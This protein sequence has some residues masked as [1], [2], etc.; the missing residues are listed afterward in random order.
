MDFMDERDFERIKTDELNEGISIEN[1][2]LV[3]AWPFL[4]I[5]FSKLGLIENSN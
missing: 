3:I 5:L 2:G 4:N 1:A